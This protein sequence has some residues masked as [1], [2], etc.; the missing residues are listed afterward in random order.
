MKKQIQT[1]FWAGLAAC[2]LPL[3]A[4]LLAYGR[5][6][7]Q[8]AVQWSGETGEVTSLMSKPWAVIAIPI[9][10]MVMHWVVYATV[11]SMVLGPRLMGALR[12]GLGWLIPL[13]SVAM[14]SVIYGANLTGRIQVFVLLFSLMGLAVLIVAAHVAELPFG[15]R[16]GVQDRFSMASEENWNHIHMVTGGIWGLCGAAVM[17]GSWLSPLNAGR[18]LLW[19]VP[20]IVPGIYSHWMGRRMQQS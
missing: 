2:A 6:P 4:G 1:P 3:V 5:L 18:M 13:L 17:L 16:W 20:M 14:Y 11:H 19:L 12:E 8:M 9:V 7:G 15:S 10:L